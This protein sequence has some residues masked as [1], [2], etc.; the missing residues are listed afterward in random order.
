MLSFDLF[1]KIFATFRQFLNDLN[2]SCPYSIHSLYGRQPDTKSNL[3]TCPIHIITMIS[4][5]N[6]NPIA[7]IGDF[8]GDSFKDERLIPHVND[9]T[10]NLNRQL[11]LSVKK[12]CTGGTYQIE[13][14]QL[15]FLINPR[16]LIPRVLA[17]LL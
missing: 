4:A 14:F 17:S 7:L 6:K 2:Y 15:H 16:F 1:N 12:S 3:N 11:Y 13:N 9:F 10:A 8:Y 5:A